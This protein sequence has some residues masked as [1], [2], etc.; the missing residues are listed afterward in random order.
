LLDSRKC[1]IEGCSREHIARGWCKPHYYTWKRWGDP[2]G[3]TVFCHRCGAEWKHDSRGRPFRLC[4]ECRVSWAICRGCE[5]ILPAFA[6]TWEGP[7]T[8]RARCK[9]CEK[10]RSKPVRVNTSRDPEQVRRFNLARYGITPEQWQRMYDEQNGCCGLCGDKPEKL[11]TDHCHENG[12][13]RRL[14]CRDCNTGLGM[15]RDDPER[16]KRAIAYLE[17]NGAV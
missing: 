11:V 3:K 10:G 1:S 14:L 4:A 2:L 9:E 17:V 12:H 7:T 16:L 6:F 13:V 8:P 5:Q 15:F